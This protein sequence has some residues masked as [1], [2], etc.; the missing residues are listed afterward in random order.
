MTVPGVG[1][2]VNRGQGPHTTGRQ[3]SWCERVGA[4]AVGDGRE[5]LGK[6]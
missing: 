6:P 5:A 2:F 1:S 4:G 3:E